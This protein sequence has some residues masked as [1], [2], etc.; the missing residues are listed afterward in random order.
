MVTQVQV[1][2]CL[3][4]GD[5]KAILSDCLVATVD[6]VNDDALLKTMNSNILMHT[7]SDDARLRI[8]SLACSEILW[9]AHGGKLLGRS[10]SI[11]DL[12]KLTGLSRFCSRNSD[13][14]S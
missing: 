1:C 3:N 2:V 9:R 14:H 4:S 6:I 12:H 11:P 8:F 5:G 7:R 13:I 10:I